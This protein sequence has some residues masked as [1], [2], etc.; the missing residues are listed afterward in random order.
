MVSRFLLF[1]SMM[2]MGRLRSWATP[3]AEN[4]DYNDVP[5][6]CKARPIL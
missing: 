4:G 3:R 2:A 6:L 5:Y 1:I